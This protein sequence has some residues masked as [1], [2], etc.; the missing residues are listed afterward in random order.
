MGYTYDDILE[1]YDEVFHLYIDRC[2]DLLSKQVGMGAVGYDFRT[3]ERK[4][5]DKFLTDGFED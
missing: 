4:A 5:V 3:E 2:F 1:M